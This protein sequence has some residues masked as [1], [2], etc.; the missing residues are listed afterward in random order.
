MFRWQRR[1]GLVQVALLLAALCSAT[2]C[3]SQLDEL[4]PRTM[5]SPRPAKPVLDSGTSTQVNDAVAPDAGEFYDGGVLGAVDGASVAVSGEGGAWTS[6][7]NSTVDAGT[8]TEQGEVDAA[9]WVEDASAVPVVPVIDGAVVEERDSG[10]DAGG[11]FPDWAIANALSL[12]QAPGGAM[13]QSIQRDVVVD[14]NVSEWGAEGW[15]QMAHR[16]ATGTGGEAKAETGFAASLALRWSSRVLFLAVVVLDDL[17]HNPYT[18]YEL[19]MG[20]SLQVAFDS[21]SGRHPYDWEYGVAISRGNAEAQRWLPDNAELTDTMQ[22]AVKRYDAGTIYEVA[23]E[24]EDL[25][26][27]TLP[28]ALRF[29]AAVNEAEGGSRIAALELVEGIVGDPKSDDAFVPIVWV[30]QQ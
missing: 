4:A 12:G 15:V 22:F 21:D 13:L 20:D 19:W 17:H 9:A 23:F 25:G 28:S 24:A 1:A 6:E 16:S 29:S 5:S 26:A 10:A 3:R 8:D 7:G 18:A 30:Q 14:G 11:G 27:S 2:G